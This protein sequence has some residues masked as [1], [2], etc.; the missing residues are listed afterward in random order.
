MT[1]ADAQMGGC[2]Q[3]MNRFRSI[4]DTL[5]ALTER[6]KQNSDWSDLCL[7]QR[8]WESS[9]ADASAAPT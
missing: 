1:H 8:M 4:H 7:K 5:G 6:F 3:R 2:P 9:D